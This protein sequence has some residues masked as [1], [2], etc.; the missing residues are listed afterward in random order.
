MPKELL[1][2]KFKHN[3]ERH[4][5]ELNRTKE[6]LMA[7]YSAQEAFLKDIEEVNRI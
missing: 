1:E 7:N 3:K 6:L 4:K 5:M 2:K